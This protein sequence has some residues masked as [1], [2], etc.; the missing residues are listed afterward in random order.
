M[1]Y[2]YNE[3]LKQE[4]WQ[5]EEGKTFKRKGSD[6]IVGTMLVRFAPS[7]SIENYEEIAIEEPVEEVIPDQTEQPSEVTPSRIP[8][9]GN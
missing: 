2:L 3:I 6:T 9:S 8:V 1:E 7:D 4:I 5:A